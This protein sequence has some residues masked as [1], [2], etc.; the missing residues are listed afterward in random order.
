LIIFFTTFQVQK[1]LSSILSQENSFCQIKPVNPVEE[2]LET[3]LTLIKTGEF[4]INEEKNLLFVNGIFQSAQDEMISERKEE[5]SE[6]Y[7]DLIDDPFDYHKLSLISILNRHQKIMKNQ[8]NF[9]K[10]QEKYFLESL[11]FATKE[12]KI[13]LIKYLETLRKSRESSKKFVK[14][15]DLKEFFKIAC[16]DMSCAEIL[17]EFCLEMDVTVE[18]LL[19][20][21]AKIKYHDGQILMGIVFKVIWKNEVNLI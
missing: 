9:I 14:N 6:L 10:F 2:S 4:K 20:I 17:I 18:D 16:S 7:S 12:N 19:N 1:L 21:I 11:K 3:I 5:I 13:F 15:L 8:E